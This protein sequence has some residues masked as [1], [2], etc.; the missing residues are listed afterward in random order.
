[1]E[2]PPG[3]VQKMPQPDRASAD[4]RCLSANHFSTAGIQQAVNHVFRGLVFRGVCGVTGGRSPGMAVVPSHGGSSDPEDAVDPC[5]DRGCSA[6]PGYSGRSS[7]DVGQWLTWTGRSGTPSRR[8]YPAIPSTTSSPCGSPSGRNGL[9]GG[10]L[11][12]RG[13]DHQCQQRVAANNRRLSQR[14]IRRH[15]PPRHQR[16]TMCGLTTDPL[17]SGVPWR[18]HP[19]PA[20][21]VLRRGIRHLNFYEDRGHVSPAVP[22]V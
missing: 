19:R 18:V 16:Q 13:P 9:G 3:L 2:Q 7:S 20:K 6:R 11:R 15:R 4:C 5:R 21:A 10:T 12:L 22:P 8:P 1:M 14:G 17:S